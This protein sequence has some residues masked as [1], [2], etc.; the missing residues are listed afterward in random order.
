MPSLLIDAGNSSVK[1]SILHHQQLGR[2]QRCDYKKPAHQCV[3]DIINTQA[4]EINTIF[5]ASVLG[6]QFI[7]KIK[8]NCQQHN[9][10]LH[11]FESQKS[12]AG[13]QNG[14]DEPQ[15][16]GADR[17]LAML[18]AKH[19]YPGDQA[20]VIIDSGTAT[21]IDALDHTGKHWGGLI[22]P[23]VH[24]CSDSLLQNTQQL[25]LWGKNK[26][27]KNRTRLYAKNT[28]EAIQSASVLGLA[29][30]I[31]SISQAMQADLAKTSR[32]TRVITGGNAQ[33]LQPYLQSHY[34]L[35]EDL[36]MLGLKVFAG[37]S[38]SS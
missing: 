34:E 13:I 5:I 35:N 37:I 4:K 23:G 17:L 36:V 21:T 22:L 32:V 33:I 11:I 7:E 31:D 12:F 16:L 30:A 15:K 6:K 3:N 20:F 8:E 25:S 10:N 29:G 19:Y 1:W 28:T 2:L 24:L 27:H 9:Y 38:A 18:G 26:P 14:Y